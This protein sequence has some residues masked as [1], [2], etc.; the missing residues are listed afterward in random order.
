MTFGG[1]GSIGKITAHVHDDTPGQGGQLNDDTQW[2]LG[3]KVWTLASINAYVPFH[4][5]SGTQANTGGK[6]QEETKWNNTVD[7]ITTSW[8]IQALLDAI[9]SNLVAHDHSSVFTGGLLSD[10]TKWHSAAQGNVDI[11]IAGL[12]THVQ[13]HVHSQA[14]NQGGVLSD[15]TRW[16]DQSSTPPAL[17]GLGDV[18]AHVANHAHD[19]DGQNRGGSLKPSTTWDYDSIGYQIDNILANVPDHDHSGSVSPGNSGGLLNAQT[20]VAIGAAQLSLEAFL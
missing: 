20:R 8:T 10:A 13:P 17:R 14:T 18:Y 1:G 3:T 9:E 11:P 4:D 12:Y 15:L 16:N 19:G 2:R 6:L 7:G 5:H